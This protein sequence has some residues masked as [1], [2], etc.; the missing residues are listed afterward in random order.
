MLPNDSTRPAVIF[1][2]DEPRI[3]KAIQRVVS[4]E[5]YDA[6]FAE[7]G[8][9]ALEILHGAQVQVM[10]CDLKMPRMDGLTLFK[11]VQ[12]DY[13][14]I[15]RIVLSAITDIE[16][17]LEAIYVGNIYRYITKPYIERELLATIRQALDSW[18]VQKDKRDLQD[19]LAE[20]N[21]LLERRVKERTAQLLAIQRQAELGRYASQ[22]VHNL[23]N[24]LQAVSGQISL[25]L[26]S[27]HRKDRGLAA[28]E[29]HLQHMRD[30][31]DRLTNIVSGILQHATDADHFTSAEIQL[32]QVIEDEVQFFEANE[33][34][35]Y[36][37]D[38]KIDL[39]PDLPAIW[40]NRS[41]LQQILDNLINNALDAMAEC[42]P[43]ILT[44]ATH[45]RDGFVLLTVADTGTGIDPGNR[46]L[47]FL[48]D[49]TTKP[50]G[51]GT[52]LGLASVKTMV[53]SYGG[54]IEVHPNHPQ[55]A[56][57]VISLPVRQSE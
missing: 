11:R 31:A 10:V 24:P 14:E 2:D 39:D 52:G 35:K 16:P 26:M 28:V 33:T 42:R 38:K 1:V 46:P 4:H 19:Q 21:R 7:G 5:P 27:L 54:R 34:F 48:P 36:E 44:I 12:Q 53:E 18:Q 25:A 23:K 37:A 15:I 29:K 9:Q 55:G 49:F 45:A 8:A 51:K 40:A 13:P 20:H 56:K 43:K 57:F 30:A 17:I 47:I 32:N 41:H 50:P 3:L 6:L 22:I